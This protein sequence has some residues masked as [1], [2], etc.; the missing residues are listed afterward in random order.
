MADRGFTIT[1]DLKKKGI[2]LL[3][4]DFKGHDRTQITA[5]ESARSEYISKARIHVERVIQRIKTFYLLERVIKLNMQDLV[6]QIFTTC[7]YLTNFQLPI[8]KSL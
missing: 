3:I 6:E 7:A 8:I 5:S 4:P 1:N 2:S